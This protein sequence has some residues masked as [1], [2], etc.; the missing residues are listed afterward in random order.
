MQKRDNGGRWK[1]LGSPEFELKVCG[2][3][4]SKMIPI[5][6]SLCIIAFS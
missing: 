1:K 6:T 2:R 4:N 5:G 3:Q